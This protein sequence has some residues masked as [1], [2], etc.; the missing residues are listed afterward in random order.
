MT[1]EVFYITTDGKLMM[2]NTTIYLV[3]KDGK[4]PLPI[5]KIKVL[6]FLGSGS[7]ST[8]VLKEFKRRN[9]PIHFF[10]RK[11]NYVGSF[12]PKESLVSGEIIVRQVKAYLD[13]AKRI[14]LA[15]KFTIGA[16]QNI[17]WICNRFNLGAIPEPNFNEA[18]T[19]EQLMQKEGNV[20]KKFYELIDSK[21]PFDFKIERREIMP[22]SNRG[23]AILSF[24]NSLVY[25]T[26]ASEIYFTH[27]HPAISFL[28]EPFERRYSLSLDVAEIFKPLLSERLLL[29]L[30][31]LKM[32]DPIVDFM[33][34]DG[35][36]LS[37]IGRKKLIKEYEEELNKTI[38]LKNKNYTVKQLIRN[39]LYKIEKDLLEL[40]EYRPLKAW[41]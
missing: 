12:Y 25:T 15:S 24:L 2:K 27:L 18:A 37:E 26:V 5:E 32:L 17:S 8:S 33:D 9:I 19:I 30:A 22:P 6:Y 3:N 7:V 23:N 40:E 4:I 31:N 20:R 34:K 16:F 13:P 11:S 41:W 21:L 14:R 28:H 10:D 1:D 39:E 36:F 35:V 29:R 38:K